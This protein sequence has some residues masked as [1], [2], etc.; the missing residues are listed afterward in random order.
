MEK[1]VMRRNH[2][3]LMVPKHELVKEYQQ[4]VRMNGQPKALPFD[5]EEQ[6]LKV[7]FND[8]VMPESKHEPVIEEYLWGIRCGVSQFVDLD[9]CS[10]SEVLDIAKANEMYEIYSPARV[11]YYLDG[12][13]EVI[14]QNI[15][16]YNTD[17]RFSDWNLIDIKQAETL[18]PDEQAN[19]AKF[20]K[21]TKFLCAPNVDRI[22]IANQEEN[23]IGMSFEFVDTIQPMAFFLG[24]LRTMFCSIAGRIKANKGRRFCALN[25]MTEVAF[26]KSRFCFL[27]GGCYSYAKA[28]SLAS[29]DELIN[30]RRHFAKGGHQ[31]FWL[32]IDGKFIVNADGL[33]RFVQEDGEDFTICVPPSVYESWGEPFEAAELEII[34]ASRCYDFDY[35][36]NEV[37]FNK[38]NRLRFDRVQIAA[39]EAGN[40]NIVITEEDVKKFT[41]AQ[42]NFEE[43]LKLI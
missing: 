16:C 12:S 6:E 18:F 1:A 13:R 7:D 26:V 17:V 35:S 34:N 11:R 29:E 30:V 5:D 9:K 25:R 15:S 20:P 24:N 40:G 19:F 21:E 10:F 38:I 22:R 14:P 43:L 41:K 4:R 28:V 2:G 31:N 32:T 33:N 27:A 23:E 39:V 42:T 3:Y 36:A 8:W 37:Y